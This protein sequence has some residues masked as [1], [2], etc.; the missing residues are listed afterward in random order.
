[1]K[2]IILVGGFLL[3]SLVGSSQ[4]MAINGTVKD[5][6]GE[7]L[8]FASILLLPDSVTFFTD[9][10]GNFAIQTLAGNKQ[11]NVSYTGYKT[12]QTAFTLRRDTVIRFISEQLVAELK[13]VTVTDRRYSQSDWIETTRSGTTTISPEEVNSIPMLGGEADLIKVLQLLPGTIR[14]VEG[15]SDLFVRGGAADQNLVLLDDAPIYNTSHLFGFLSVFSPEIL[16]NVESV[17][18]GFPANYGGRLSS[19]LNVETISD[20]ADETH[21]S[22]NIGLLASRLFV[23]QPLVKNK[24][25]IWITGRRTYVDQV[26]KVIGEELPYFFYDLNGKIILT[27]S[28]RDNIQI[29][30]YGGK[31]VLDIF[32]DQNNDGD[33]FL[34]TYTSGNNSQTVRWQRT[35]RSGW[36]GKLSFIRTAYSYDI[37][38]SFEDN[39]SVASS[40]IED[41]GTKLLFSKKGSKS[42]II[43]GADWTRHEVSPSILNVSGTFSELFGSSSSPGRTAHEV[44]VHAQ[45]EWSVSSRWAINSGVRTS[46]AFVTNKKYIVPEPRI[47]ARYKIG[48]DESLKLSY[49]RM[50]QYVHRISNSAITSP[51]DIWYPVTD[52]IR[53]QTAHQVS[54]AWQRLLSKKIYV[55]IESYYKSMDDIIGFEEGTNLIFNPDFQSKLIQGKGSAYGVEVLVKKEAGKFTGWISYSLSWAWR[56]FDELNAGARF[57]SRYDR[58]HNG[59][60]VM[61]YAFHEKWSVSAVWEFISGSRFTPVIG[62]YVVTSPTGVGVELLPVYAP[63]NSVRLANTH[64]LDLG[65]KY[66][67]DPTKRFQ[68]EIFLGV[69]NAYNRAN[70]VGINVEQDERTG[71][72][73]YNQPGLFGVIPF[74]SYGFKF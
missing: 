42:L 65:I 74:V 27:P 50:A 54:I 72:L 37:L 43:W 12:I 69:Y 23:E 60:V 46:M 26:V 51:T 22:G 5:K 28:N 70:P 1:M 30:Y 64:R 10:K 6:A 39:R 63:L 61:Q 66:K 59:A 34:T 38:N 2:K 40:D 44:A 24:A 21:V 56:K 4:S 7:L 31:D 35:L 67:T 17:N 73:K 11:L 48:K 3:L 8:P 15:S 53:P 13:E 14:G 57:P 9:S 25:S 55:S 36:N 45:Y 47:S 18:G 58:R 68:S 71:E 62:Q 32:R 49:S 16:Q 19:V 41:I 20:I 33:G 29:S 52:S